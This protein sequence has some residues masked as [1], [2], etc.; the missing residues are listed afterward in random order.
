MKRST[1]AGIACCGL[2]I[3]LL[4]GQQPAPPAVQAGDEPVAR[5]VAEAVLLDLVVRDKDGKLVR[6]LRPEEVEILDNNEPQIILNFEFHGESGIEVMPLSEGQAAGGPVRLESVLTPDASLRLVNLVTLVFDNLGLES[7]A[8]ARRAAEAF[9]ERDA[10]TNTWVAVF[11][12]ARRLIVLE[13]FSQDRARLKAAI[14]EATSQSPIQYYTKS[15]EIYAQM[16]EVSR[17][18]EQAET[19]AS[20]GGP[21]AAAS[22][23]LMAQAKMAELIVNM[24]QYS[25]TLDQ[26]AQGRSS[27]YGLLSLVQGQGALE[28]R[29]TLIYFSE[30]LR[31]MPAVEA[32][33]NT[34]IGEANR[35][36]VSVYSVDARGLISGGHLDSARDMLSGAADASRAQQQN[37]ARP[38]TREQA[39]LADRQDEIGRQNVQAAL[40]DLAVSTGGMLIANTN[41][42]TPGMARVSDDI[43]SHYE[44]AYSPRNLVYD[45]SF[46]TVQVR[47]KRPG[48]TVQSRSGYFALPVSGGPVLLP[49]ERNML[50]VLASA[51]L[52]SDLQ[53]RSGILRF[54]RTRDRFSHTVILELPLADLVFREN[55]K[56]KQYEADF[57]LLALIKDR[58]GRVVEKLS[59][60]YPVR[61]PIKNMQA[62]RRGDAV[63]LRRVD[64]VPGQYTLEAVAHDQAASKFTA[65]R[66]RFEVPEPAAGVR[67][68]SVVVVKRGEEVD[69]KQVSADDPLYFQNTK[70]VPGLGEPVVKSD[71]NKLVL[72][73]TIYPDPSLAFEPKLGLEFSHEGKVLGAT[74]PE[75]PDRDEQGR[76]PFFITFPMKLFP[77][78]SHRVRAVVQQGNSFDESAAEFIV[79]Q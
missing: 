60:S 73:M 72:F 51:S 69:E 67:L 1:G 35:K 33:F 75:L 28:G 12:V 6:D 52:P 20:A 78:G 70:I 32:L 21:G 24:L 13:Q 48:V 45:G 54:D 59:Q 11:N 76:I 36:N 34:V 30:G 37:P 56:E 65:Q 63:F 9:V 77:P 26:E 22:G 15:D 38:V 62:V 8:L 25:K 53:L 19:A 55:K 31:V 49:F 47:V 3:A 23:A 7:A 71:D 50:A 40:G 16:Q 68:S 5:A 27:L 61:G 14:L 74:Q 2:S 44:L 18:T 46:R 10:G 39:M 66:I 17:L 29:K 58:E 4:W 57:A 79:T 43:Y 41:D 42:F 64:L